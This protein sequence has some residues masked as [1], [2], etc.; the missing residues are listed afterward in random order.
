DQYAEAL[1]PVHDQVSAFGADI[2]GLLVYWRRANHRR[3]VP[4]GGTRGG[5]LC[6]AR[7]GVS[8]AS[9]GAALCCLCQQLGDFIE[10]ADTE[11]NRQA[12]NS[13]SGR[14]GQFV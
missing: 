2:P 9:E 11:T 13:S 7:R 4:A 12:T 8:Q 6:E 14:V 1:D 5:V 3:H 10:S